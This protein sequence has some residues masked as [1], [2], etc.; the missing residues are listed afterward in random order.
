MKLSWNCGRRS[1]PWPQYW[2]A[3]ILAM[4][5][6]GFP[7]AHRKTTRKPR[8][9]SGPARSGCSQPWLGRLPLFPVPVPRPAPASLWSSAMQTCLGTR[10]LKQPGISGQLLSWDQVLG[11]RRAKEGS[12]VRGPPG[13]L[14]QSS[15]K[16][17]AQDFVKVCFLGVC[18]MA[19][20]W[21]N[22][23]LGRGD[24]FCLWCSCSV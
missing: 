24:C 8:P 18:L 15:G 7:N 12:L 19:L 14:S 3:T 13:C 20:A 1:R 21:S 16:M 5:V 11:Q 4:K 6:G 17:A 23:D 2:W 9:L 22:V 10:A